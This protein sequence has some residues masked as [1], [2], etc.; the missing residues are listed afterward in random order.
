M[1]TIPRETK[2]TGAYREYVQTL[3]T[4][5]YEFLAKTR[6]LLNVSKANTLLCD[7]LKMLDFVQEQSACLTQFE[8]AWS[9]GH[10]QGWAKEQEKAAHG[11]LKQSSGHLDLSPYNSPAELAALGLDRL[12]G[13]LQALGLKCG[14]C[15]LC[16]LSQ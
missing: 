10:F 1:D 6:P 13:A 12:K 2:K 3:L 11:A 14:G 15:V 5:I 8:R 4:Y 16:L 7:T 9:E